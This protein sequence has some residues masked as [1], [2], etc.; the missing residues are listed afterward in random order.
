[1][2]ESQVRKPAAKP[3]AM[4]DEEGQ[5][6]PDRMT[7]AIAVLGYGAAIFIVFLLFWLAQSV[8]G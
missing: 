2:L 5:E 6:M 3:T 8:N 7:P 1:M 4:I